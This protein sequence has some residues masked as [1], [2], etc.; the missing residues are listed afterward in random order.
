MKIKFT[1]CI[2]AIMSML[3]AATAQSFKKKQLDINIGLGLGNTFIT[4]GY[5]RSLPAISTS[6]EYGITD[7]IIIGGYLGYTGATYNYYG[8]EWC[9]NGNHYGNPYGEFY[10][11]TDTYSWNYYIIGI[12][13]AYHFSRFI[14][15]EKL[16]VYLG[17]L[18]GN[19]FA[20]YT[21]RTNSVCNDHYSYV[22]RTSAGF[23]FSV[24]GGARYRFTEHVGA[25]A[26]L[27]YGISYLT[28]GLNLK[29]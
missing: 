13:G 23:I 10:N 18:F 16:D 17:G 5:T 28:V 6:I 2:V 27:G 19:N 22:N 8:T 14:K 7:E 29:F 1:L 12:R 4:R 9:D 25:F 21:Y 11:Y 15:N 24:Y 26:E 20:H 3:T